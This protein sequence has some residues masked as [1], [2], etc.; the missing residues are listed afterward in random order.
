MLSLKKIVLAVAVSSTGVQAVHRCKKKTNPTPTHTPTP[1]S[2]HTSTPTHKPTPPHE[3]TCYY[4][5]PLGG[6]GKKGPAEKITHEKC[7]EIVKSKEVGVVVG[8][9]K[10]EGKR[11]CPPS[12]KALKKHNPD[13]KCS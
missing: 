5:A 9:F 7:E 6:K 1:T 11:E 4:S 10:I 2:R 12:S 13:N 8:H 3:E